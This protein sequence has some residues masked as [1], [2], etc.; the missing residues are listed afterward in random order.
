MRQMLAAEA[1]RHLCHH[2]DVV[3]VAMKRVRLSLFSRRS[4]TDRTFDQFLTDELLELERECPEYRLVMVSV[5][6]SD[7]SLVLEKLGHQ[8]VDAESE[9]ALEPVAEPEVAHQ[10]CEQP[11]TRTGVSTTRACVR[12][13]AI[14]WQSGEA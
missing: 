2:L 14:H 12:E 11:V 1:C 7:A 5:V 4:G 8:A 10:D 6:F 3:V 13:F 9:Q